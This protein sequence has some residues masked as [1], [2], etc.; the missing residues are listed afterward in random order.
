VSCPK[1][2]DRGGFIL[3]ISGV[4]EPTD[5]V[6]NQEGVVLSNEHSYIRKISKVM[7]TVTTICTESVGNMFHGD[8]VFHLQEV[9][10]ENILCRNMSQSVQGHCLLLDVVGNNAPQ[11]EPRINIDLQIQCALKWI[12][13]KFITVTPLTK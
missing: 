4:F 6:V 7:T 9:K 1:P 5:A 11:P 13:L 12:N 8:S 10:N 3:R 2:N